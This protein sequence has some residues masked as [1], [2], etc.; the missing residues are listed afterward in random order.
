LVDI[1]WTTKYITPEFLVTLC[2]K[3]FR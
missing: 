2:L 3:S 1:F